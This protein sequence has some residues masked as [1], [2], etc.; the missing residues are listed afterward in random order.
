MVPLLLRQ[1]ELHF[2]Q[3]RSCFEDCLH[4]LAQHQI[5]TLN[6][7]GAE[8]RSILS[9][10]VPKL[11]KTNFYHCY[12]FATIIGHIQNHIRQTFLAASA[13]KLRVELPQKLEGLVIAEDI[14]T[15]KDWRYMSM[16]QD[17]S[18]TTSTF[19]ILGITWR[20]TCLFLSTT[21]TSNCTYIHNMYLPSQQNCCYCLQ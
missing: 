4:E 17:S 21:F 14:S 19:T 12:H 13:K 1:L 7:N 11:L 5:G 16:V 6:V 20:T 15:R 18:A 9:F 10:P 3:N 2:T 8:G